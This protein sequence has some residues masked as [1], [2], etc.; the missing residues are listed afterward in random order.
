MMLFV[1]M[2][3]IC[4]GHV[5]KVIWTPYAGELLLMRKEPANTR[6]GMAATAP[7]RVTCVAIVIF[8]VQIGSC[9]CQITLCNVARQQL[10]TRE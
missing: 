3:V 5:Y 7:A 10:L 6:D 2:A 9:L 1:F 4:Q 8:S